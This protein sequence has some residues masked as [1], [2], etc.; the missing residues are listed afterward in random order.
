MCAQY[1]H[2]IAIIS[3]AVASDLAKLKL[4]SAEESWTK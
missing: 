2:F 1:S 3:M 4:L